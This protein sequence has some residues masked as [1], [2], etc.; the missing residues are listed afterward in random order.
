M[1]IK[2][3]VGSRTPIVVHE[4]QDKTCSDPKGHNFNPE[5]GARYG[6]DG[7]ECLHCGHFTG[8]ERFDSLEDA[9]SQYRGDYVRVAVI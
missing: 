8:V 3:F 2:F 4:E 1:F 5:D 7:N 6:I 9:V